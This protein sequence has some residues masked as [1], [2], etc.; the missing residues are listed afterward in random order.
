MKKQKP[1]NEL[2]S[3][4][5]DHVFRRIFGQLDVEALADFFSTVLDMSAEDF[6]EFRQTVGV[7]TAR[8]LLLTV[9]R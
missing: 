1:E 4:L 6:V 2:L 7:S 8:Q 3:L 5:N 9:K